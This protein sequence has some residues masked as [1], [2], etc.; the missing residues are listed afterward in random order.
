[1]S[2]N[3]LLNVF[4]D[5]D[6]QVSHPVGVAAVF[7]VVPAE[8]LGMDHGNLKHFFAKARDEVR[9]QIRNV[10]KIDRYESR[11]GVIELDRKSTRLNSS[12]RLLSR[13]PSSA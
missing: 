12:H 9:R 1:M 3:S 8:N 7:I 10:G 13:M 5:I 6:G 4:V 2:I 11:A